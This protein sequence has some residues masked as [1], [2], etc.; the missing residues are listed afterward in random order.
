[1]NQSHRRDRPLL[2]VDYAGGEEEYSE[3]VATAYFGLQKDMQGQYLDK[4]LTIERLCIQLNVLQRDNQHLKKL[5]DMHLR[6][7]RPLIVRLQV[8]NMAWSSDN[9]QR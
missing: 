9:R 6:H 5:K 1:M 8:S 3:Q 7:I 2:Y 4:L